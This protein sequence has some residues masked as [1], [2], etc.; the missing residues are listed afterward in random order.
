MGPRLVFVLSRAGCAVVALWLLAGPAVAATP[1]ELIKTHYQAYDAALERGDLA[2]AEKEAASALAA[3]QEGYGDGGRTA[4]LALNLAE[5]RLAQNKNREAL[6]PARQALRLAEK[7]GPASGVDDRVA[8]L[9]LARI[10]LRTGDKTAFER[11]QKAVAV[12]VAAPELARGAYPG[13]VDLAVSAETLRRYDDA[14]VAWGNIASIARRQPDFPPLLLARAQIGEASNA[15]LALAGRERI[16][17]TGSR[18]KAPSTEPYEKL[19][20]ALALVMQSTAPAAATPGPTSAPT[21]AQVV[22]AQAMGWRAVIES[23]LKIDRRPA[24]L[25][26]KLGELDI[27]PARFPLPRC[28][29]SI[30]AKPTPI[31][32]GSIRFSGG[33]GAVVLKLMFDEQGKVK[34]MS[35]ATT[36]GGPDFTK[37]VTDVAGQWRIEKADP[38]A[39]GCRLARES[40]LN[41]VYRVY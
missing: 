25:G 36:L 38:D 34:D 14:S 17:T 22:Y 3:S 37:A 18:V 4:V 40:F 26:E 28:D 39:T 5:V 33:I 8:R 16:P 7:N 10:E 41:L 24:D 35:V 12:A 23:K 27:G 21:E 13:A 6:E 2:S 1:A 11:L 15:F 31:I 29:V 19:D 32:P 30:V 9:A 20:A